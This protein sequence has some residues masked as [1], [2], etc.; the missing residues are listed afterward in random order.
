V[1]SHFSTREFRIEIIY[2]NLNRVILALRANDAR[3]RC[4]FFVFFS[5][6]EFTVVLPCA[7]NSGIAQF[8]IGLV[9]EKRKKK[10]LN[11]TPLRLRL[12]KE[13]TVRGES[14]SCAHDHHLFTRTYSS[15]SA[16]IHLPNLL[17]AFDKHRRRRSRREK[18]IF[19]FSKKT[20]KIRFA[21]VRVARAP[22]T[23]SFFI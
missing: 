1:R 2:F 17:H 10:P 19:R 4:N 3:C 12:K 5:F 20:R 14:V 21:H 8:G 13:C 11:G 23:A 22:P 7:G 16:V 15:V 9:I 6:A 18:E